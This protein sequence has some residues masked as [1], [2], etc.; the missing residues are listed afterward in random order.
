MEYPFGIYHGI[1]SVDTP[2]LS[3]RRIVYDEIDFPILTGK[4]SNYIFDAEVSAVL[5]DNNSLK[6][7]VQTG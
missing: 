6:R 4:F 3:Y 7:S 5:G 1:Q 2:N